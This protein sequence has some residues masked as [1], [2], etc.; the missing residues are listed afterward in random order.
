M[1]KRFNDFVNEKYE[2]DHE[3]DRI[4]DKIS[5]KGIDSITPEERAYLNGD[6]EE[7]P[8]YNGTYDDGYDTID[9]EGNYINPS[10]DKYIFRVFDNEEQDTYGDVGVAVFDKNDHFMIDIHVSDELFPELKTIGLE[11]LAE[12]VLEYSGKL[13]KEELTDKLISMG[14]KAIV[15]DV[16]DSFT[17]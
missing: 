8:E 16:D 2:A 3:L 7:E 4:L 13:S 10:K 15:K 9:D 11:D 6:S 14:F 12:G 17:Y 1:I 5:E